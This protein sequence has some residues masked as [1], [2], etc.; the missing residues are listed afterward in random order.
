[1]N[2]IPQTH[3]QFLNQIKKKK[4]MSHT[5]ISSYKLKQ[6]KIHRK[7]SISFKKN[8]LQ[9][10]LKSLGY[11]TKNMSFLKQRKLLDKAMTELSNKNTKNA[12]NE[13]NNSEN[14]L[15]F[16]KNN[17]LFIDRKQNK[18]ENKNENKMKNKTNNNNNKNKIRSKIIKS[19]LHGMD[20]EFG[21]IVRP[22]FQREIDMETV[23]RTGKSNKK[24]SDR[25]LLKVL[26]KRD[27][28]IKKRYG[29]NNNK[30]FIDEHLVNITMQ[31]LRGERVKDDL[32]FMKNKLKQ[33][34]KKKVKSQR[35][36][37]Q[38]IAKKQYSRNIKIARRE[39]NIAVYR[40]RKSDR[41]IGNRISA[42]NAIAIANM[43]L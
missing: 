23:I 38:R 35:K 33:K 43:E 24:I 4:N 39:G 5:K 17:D 2:K 18:N 32:K 14:I 22:N 29:N 16:M 9:S 25:K 37:K 13:N 31:K 15:G 42:E 28:A 40:Q 27:K 30:V 21:E 6:N 19:D 41:R 3:F 10:N 34:Y 11:D 20:L 1:M 7:N 26:K 12:K 8:Q 36:W